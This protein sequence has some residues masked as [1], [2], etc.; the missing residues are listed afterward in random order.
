MANADYFLPQAGAQEAEKN[1]YYSEYY[2]QRQNI[3]CSFIGILSRHDGLPLIV[4]PLFIP[5]GQI[6]SI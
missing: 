2:Y 5:G 1:Q 6:F 3:F 4:Y